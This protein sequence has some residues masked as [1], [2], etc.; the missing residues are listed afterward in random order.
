LVRW[1]D[2]V[3]I[4]L[5]VGLVAIY[6]AAKAHFFLRFGDMPVEDYLAEHW[7][8]WAV[9]LVFALLANVIGRIREAR[10]KEQSNNEMQRTKP[11]QSVLRR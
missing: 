9:A 4:V 5:V 10:M 6:V 1:A 2:R 7:P 11:A 3:L 8:F